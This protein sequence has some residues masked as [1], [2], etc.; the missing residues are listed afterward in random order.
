MK[1]RF[2]CIGIVLAA[3]LGTAAA[4]DDSGGYLPMVGPAALRFQTPS[5]LHPVLPP[6][7]SGGKPSISQFSEPAKTPQGTQV[8]EET[9]GNNDDVLGKGANSLAEQAITGRAPMGSGSGR[10]SEITAQMFL[11]FFAPST[12]GRGGVV[13]MPISF[14]PAQPAVRL[15]STAQYSSTKR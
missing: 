6:L 10:A 2:Q 14:T 5:S 12:N 15:S 1:I 3:A 7:D 13:V 9:E 11:R 8:T 4:R